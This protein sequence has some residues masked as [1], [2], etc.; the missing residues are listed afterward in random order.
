MFEV[1]TNTSLRTKRYP[2]YLQGVPR[3]MRVCDSFW[4]LLWNLFWNQ[5][6]YNMAGMKIFILFSWGSNNLAN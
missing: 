3:N 5:F 1:Y 2:G 4:M 6:Y